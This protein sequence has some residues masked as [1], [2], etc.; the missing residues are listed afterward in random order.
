MICKL[1]IFVFITLTSA[2]IS[3]STIFLKCFYNS[4]REKW[5]TWK[6]E[7]YTVLLRQFS[8]HIGKE[9]K[10]NVWIIPNSRKFLNYQKW[11]KEKKILFLK[12]KQVRSFFFENVIWNNIFKHFLQCFVQLIFCEKKCVNFCLILHFFYC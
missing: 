2:C 4:I 1:N 11:N 10:K 3:L 12:L 5:H 7:C 6:S 9:V 8:E